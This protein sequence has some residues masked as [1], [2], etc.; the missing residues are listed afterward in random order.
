MCGRGGGVE[1]N[2]TNTE[3]ARHKS[4]AWCAGGIAVHGVVAVASELPDKLLGV[5]GEVD[6][7]AD[8]RPVGV[9]NTGVALSSGDRCGSAAKF[10]Y[11]SGKELKVAAAG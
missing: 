9:K 11:W 1:E 7:I 10:R 4:K 8:R 6:T 2:A 3:G 5:W